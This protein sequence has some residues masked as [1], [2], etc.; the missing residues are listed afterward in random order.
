[1]NFSQRRFRSDLRF[2]F[3]REWFI[4]TGGGHMVLLGTLVNAALIV[5]GSIIREISTEYSRKGK[6]NG[7]EWNWFSGS[8][9]GLTNDL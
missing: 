7:Y 4:T 2:N 8:S 5:I 1:M 3:S 9:Y 6:R